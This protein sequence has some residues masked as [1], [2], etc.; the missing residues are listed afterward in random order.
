MEEVA[1]GSSNEPVPLWRELLDEGTWESV[2][3][4]PALPD[5][6][7][8]AGK[9]RRAVFGVFE[10]LETTALR[11]I[12]PKHNS[13]AE[14]GRLVLVPELHPTLEV[15]EVRLHH[16]L[17]RFPSRLRWLDIPTCTRAC[18]PVVQVERK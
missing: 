8:T 11:T 5:V 4:A 9:F 13:F 15:A 3:A 6:H 17:D 2:V 10:K 7:R 16:L 18:V 1:F 14:F 12:E